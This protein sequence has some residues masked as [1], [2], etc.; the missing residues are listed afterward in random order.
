VQERYVGANQELGP[1]IDGR[2]KDLSL[3]G[4]GLFLP[5]ELPS[6]QVQI[7]LQTPTRPEEI[8]VSASITRVQ[9]SSDGWYQVGATFSDAP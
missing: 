5:P 4:I 8:A 1:R 2:G 7:F 6:R 3:T 9:V